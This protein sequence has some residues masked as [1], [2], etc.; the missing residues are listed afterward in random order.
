MQETRIIKKYP[1]RRLYDT[2]LGLYITLD[3]VKKL[4]FDRVEFKV[5]DARSKKDLTQSTLLQIITEQETTS[6]PIFTT[7]LL[8]DFI[9]SYQEK[10]QNAFTQ[11]LEQTMD[12]FLRQKSFFQNQWMTYQKLFSDA[13]WLQKALK[14]HDEENLKKKK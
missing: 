1:N 13:Q 8:Q 7:A 10:S 2:E 9:R 5:I 6:T 3:D 14:M 11:Y 12:L 4:V